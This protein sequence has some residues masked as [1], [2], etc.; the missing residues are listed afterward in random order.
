VIKHCE[1]Y[2]TFKNKDLQ[3]SPTEFFADKMTQVTDQKSAH[4]ALKIIIDQGEGSVGVEEAH[5]QM[6]LDLYMKRTEWKCWPV[7]NSPHTIMYPAGTLLSEVS[8]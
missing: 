6:F 2:I 3:F 4:H 1:D 7:P 5:Y 8:V